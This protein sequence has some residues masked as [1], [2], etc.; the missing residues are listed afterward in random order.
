MAWT[1]Q[2]WIFCNVFTSVGV[3][4]V[5]ALVLLIMLCYFPKGFYAI[6]ARLFRIKR[7]LIDVNH[8]IVKYNSELS[9]S[10]G[11]NHDIHR[12][13]ERLTHAVKRT[14]NM[15]T[16]STD[17]MT[18]KN[19]R[20]SG[21]MTGKNRTWPS[22]GTVIKINEKKP[23][24]ITSQ[25]NANRPQSQ[26]VV[27]RMELQL[28]GRNST[29]KKHSASSEGSYTAL[30][31]S[32]DPPRHPVYERV[33][34]DVYGKYLPLRKKRNRCVILMLTTVVITATI[35]AF[36]EGCILASTTAYQDRPCPPQGD[37]ECFYGPNA[38]YFQCTVQRNI[39]L[40]GSLLFAT[41]FRWVAPNLGVSDVLDQIGV[42][43][44]LLAALGAFAEVL[45]RLLLYVYQQRRC[46][47][48]GIRRILERTVGVNNITQPLCQCCTKFPIR[49]P[50]PN[51]RLYRYPT[52]VAL[53]T[54]G[55]VALV[56]ICV[57]GFIPLIYFRASVTS[58]TYVILSGIASLCFFTMVWII[59][60]VDEVC[61]VIPGG[62]RSFSDLC[63]KPT[64]NALKK[65]EILAST[66]KPDEMEAKFK[67]EAEK[68]EADGSQ[69]EPEETLLKS[70]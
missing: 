38:T 62:Y 52:L 45:V 16:S 21:K 65:L 48:N 55:Y 9:T 11:H 69:K 25:R 49:I 30:N 64:I 68:E 23:G 40:P 63:N 44:G 1:A 50:S 66:D 51:L 8:T 4:I 61:R 33:V 26:Q 36:G 34:L 15:L 19:Q 7:C 32:E 37:M 28:T 10:H 41:C 70:K 47:A 39:S 56:I 35:L 17:D 54:L 2:Q 22:P 57:L 12:F 20:T 18:S 31:V 43:T 42:C 67:E 60:E 59:W 13:S 58:F 5:T 46:V 29:S 24:R 6:V 27:P 14:R 53:V 3:F